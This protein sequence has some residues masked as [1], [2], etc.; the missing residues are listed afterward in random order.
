MRRVL[1]LGLPALLVAAAVFVSVRG[2]V[3]ADG[4]DLRYWSASCSL[5][6]SG[7]SETNA[8]ITGNCPD[9]ARTLGIMLDRDDKLAAL[10]EGK[11]ALILGEVDLTASDLMDRCAVM[12]ELAESSDWPEDIDSPTGAIVLQGLLADR[13]LSPGLSEALARI[14]F[15]PVEVTLETL[16]IGDGGD[17]YADCPSVPR[18]APIA[19][20]VSLERAS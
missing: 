11:T 3:W 18:K 9:I 2:L 16:R 17:H 5:T 4:I 14:G 7:V 20:R 1:I 15:Q 19:A 8:R 6:V 12:A 13:G 10:L